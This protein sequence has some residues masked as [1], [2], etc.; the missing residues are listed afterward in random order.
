M[1]YYYGRN[2]QLTGSLVKHSTNMFDI[3]L[4]K[5]GRKGTR[6]SIFF[7]LSRE[8]DIDSHYLSIKYLKYL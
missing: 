2:R 4:V 1:S 6:R 5:D 7:I 8:Y 3:S